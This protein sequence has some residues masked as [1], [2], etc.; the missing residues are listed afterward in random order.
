MST[1]DIKPVFAGLDMDYVPLTYWEEGVSGIPE[2]YNTPS[3]RG[4]FRLRVSP[5]KE[6]YVSFRLS[7]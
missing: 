5:I 3:R 2:L 1:I 4:P 7:R 6:V